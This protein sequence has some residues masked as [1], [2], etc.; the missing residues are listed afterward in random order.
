MEKAKIT[1]TD[2]K[3]HRMGRDYDYE[4]RGRRHEEKRD[5]HP[6]RMR[7]ACRCV[8]LVFLALGLWPFLGILFGRSSANPGGALAVFTLFGFFAVLTYVLTRY[9]L[10]RR[11]ELY[12]AIRRE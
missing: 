9:S 8:S 12:E 6:Q 5:T 4:Y 10:K 1:I 3:G 2:S 7:T 11:R